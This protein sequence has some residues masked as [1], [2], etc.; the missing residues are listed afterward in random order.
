MFIS[1]SQ[2]FGKLSTDFEPKGRKSYSKSWCYPS[3]IRW[4]N[5][6]L[7]KNEKLSVSRKNV[8]WQ[9]IP[10]IACGVTERD[11]IIFSFRVRGGGTILVG[12]QQLFE[13]CEA[14]EFVRAVAML[15][16]VK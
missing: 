5:T 9:F 14:G 6:C 13:Y 11:G 15:M 10:L 8:R 12:H 3:S 1:V 4:W 2:V 16:T 7:L